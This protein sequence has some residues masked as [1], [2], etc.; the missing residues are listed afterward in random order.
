MVHCN[1]VKTK[2]DLKGKLGDMTVHHNPKSI[3]NELFLQLVKQK[4]QV[5]YDS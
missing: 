3:A 1:A 5:T 4:H 2:T